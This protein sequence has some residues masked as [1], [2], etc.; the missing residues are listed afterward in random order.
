MKRAGFWLALLAISGG[1]CATTHN[2]LTAAEIIASAH[3]AAGGEDWVRPRT[4]TMRGYGLFF[5]GATTHR[6]DEHLMWRVYPLEKENAHQADGK[7]RIESSQADQLKFL[8][9]FDGETTYNENGP[10]PG[11]SD[12]ERWQASFGFGVIRFALDAGYSVARLPDDSIDGHEIYKVKVTDSDGGETLFGIAKA[13]FRIRWLGFDTPR[14]WHERVYSEFFTNPGVS[15]VQPGRVRL[16]YDGVKAN[17]IVW[18]SFEL[19]APLDDQLFVIQPP[20]SP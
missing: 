10:L 3:R 4:L 13:D 5:E 17:E 2:D 14:G 11:A 20:A 7:V 18:N 8:I 16:Y 19:N 15:W 12:Q 6:H 9:A 1:A